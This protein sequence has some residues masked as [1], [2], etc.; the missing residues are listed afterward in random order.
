M[1]SERPL[2]LRPRRTE[3]ECPSAAGP[4]PPP[5][6]SLPGGGGMLP[7]AAGEG[8]RSKRPSNPGDDPAAGCGAG[9]GGGG[10][11]RKCGGDNEL[12]LRCP[13]LLRIGRC[14]SGAPPVPL[15]RGEFTAALPPSCVGTVTCRGDMV[16]VSERWLPPWLPRRTDT[17][18]GAALPR[19]PL[20]SFPARAW[21][22][23]SKSRS[24]VGKCCCGCGPGGST[25]WCSGCRHCGCRRCG[26]GSPRSKRPSC[27]CCGCG[28]SCGDIESSCGDSGGVRL[29]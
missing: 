16:A 2:R 6:L 9:A 3:Y 4:P 10:G 29:L 27:M 26:C 28:S 21:D 8:S 24:M 13:S 11:E 12:P 7:S 25:V 5:G 19:P 17:D 14:P 1:D 22:G 23:G 15:W 18:T 20:R